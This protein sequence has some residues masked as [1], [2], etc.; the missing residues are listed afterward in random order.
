[1]VCWSHEKIRMK[2]ADQSNQLL[3]PQLGE[4]PEEQG[5]R[6]LA[7]IIARRLAKSRTDKYA[8]AYEQGEDD[9]PAR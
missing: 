8:S 9:S 4:D 1:V 6:I 2:A 3:D 7:K 5:L